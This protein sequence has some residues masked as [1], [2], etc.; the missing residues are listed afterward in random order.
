[1]EPS[2]PVLATCRKMKCTRCFL[3]V[4]IIANQFYEVVDYGKT[5]QRQRPTV[6]VLVWEEKIC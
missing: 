3:L 2:L 1:M 5:N 6:L 4:R